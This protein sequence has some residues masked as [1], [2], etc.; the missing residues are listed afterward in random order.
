[1]MEARLL[2]EGHEVST[3][4][5]GFSGFQKIKAVMPELIIIDTALSKSSGPQLVEK[6]RDLPGF[7]KTSIFIISD[8]VWTKDLFRAEDI[9]YFFSKPVLCVEFIEKVRL[10]LNPVA[11]GKTLQPKEEVAVPLSG[12]GR[13]LL[14]GP[15]AFIIK[16]MKDF[17][18]A[19]GFSVEIG[20]NE[21]EVVQKAAT[22]KPQYI[23]VQYWDNMNNFSVFKVEKGI[24]EKPELR[25]IPL[26]VFCHEKLASHARDSIAHE[27][28]I[29]FYESPDLLIS[30]KR[31][32]FDRQNL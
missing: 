9:A 4:G 17:F 7:L 18:E 21:A 14:A 19:N 8:Q 11:A 16:K 20:L 6:I 13:I 22:M 24:M 25:A 28:V 15:Q 10:A 26:Y 27:H 3:A 29:P 5:D 2:M 12:R 30:L 31:L 32:L 1:M 23:F